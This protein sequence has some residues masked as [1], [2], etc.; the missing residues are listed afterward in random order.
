[1]PDAATKIGCHYASIGDDAAI[2]GY[3]IAA[4]VIGPLV[5]DCQP[6]W[7]FDCAT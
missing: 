3:D 5:Y 4:K 2:V 6:D 7:N 1:M